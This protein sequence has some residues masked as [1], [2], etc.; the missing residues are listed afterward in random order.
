M[1]TVVD[2]WI[3]AREIIAPSVD[4]AYENLIIRH[5]SARPCTVSISDL[6]TASDYLLMRNNSITCVGDVDFPDI[7]EE[8][9]HDK[10][11]L[12]A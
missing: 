8:H 12:M 9:V 5:S 1:Q 2:H 4:R 10:K 7:P 11:R 3:A 6:L